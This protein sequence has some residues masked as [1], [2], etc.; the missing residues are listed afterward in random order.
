MTRP[1]D[2]ATAEQLIAAYAD[3]PSSLTADE[4]RAV[5]E[6]CARDA[7]AAKE[8]TEARMALAALREARAGEGAPDWKVMEQQ[9]AQAVMRQPVSFWRRHRTAIRVVAY[10]GVAAALVALLIGPPYLGRHV[11]S[12]PVAAEPEL[13]EEE[14][15]A[16]LDVPDDLGGIT[17][18]DALIDEAAALDDDA[19]EGDEP[20]R[21]LPDTGW[22]DELSDEELDRAVEILAQEAT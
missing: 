13:T 6:L 18:D 15:A 22:I 12:Q 20:E 8:L 1:D 3:D 2:A 5:E 9:I 19:D 14:L 4:R 16:E 17:V 21:L 11:R 10:G 7:W